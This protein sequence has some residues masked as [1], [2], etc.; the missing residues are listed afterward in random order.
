MKL[1]AFEC[2][3]DCLCV[4]QREASCLYTISPKTHQDSTSAPQATRSALLPATSPSLSCRVSQTISST[5]WELSVRLPI[6]TSPQQCTMTCIRLFIFSFWLV[7]FFFLFC[8][9]HEHW[10]DCRNHWWSC[11]CFDRAHRCNL[12]LLLQEEEER[13]GIRHGVRFFPHKK[14][15][16]LHLDWL[17]DAVKGDRG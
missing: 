4:S 1:L 15:M 8:S 5:S 14:H 2:V 6:H 13:G 9:L 11:C 12:L 16:Q 3:C 17:S 10:L 7:F